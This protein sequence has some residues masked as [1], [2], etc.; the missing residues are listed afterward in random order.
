MNTDGITAPKE[1]VSVP[2]NETRVHFWLI[3]VVQ[4]AFGG[5]LSTYLVFY[6]RSATLS[7]SWPFLLILAAA[8][9]GNEIFKHHY[10][11]LT[12]QISILFLSIY[13]F[14]IF[15]VPVILRKIG[16]QIFILS[17]AISIIILI[18]FLGL[19]YFV[20]KEKF[21]RSRYILIASIVGIIA[22]INILY[23]TNTIPPIPLALK[24]AGVY[25]SI[26]RSPD[27]NYIVTYESGHWY[28]F[29]RGYSDVHEVEGDPI[30]VFSA[31]FSPAMFNTNIVDVWQY[32]DST[33]HKWINSARIPLSTLGGRDDGFRTY[34]EKSNVAAGFWRVSVE[35][36]NG[37]IIGRIKFKVI[38]STTEAPLLA[39]IK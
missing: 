18:V 26:S 14:A 8:F 4:F 25:H 7:V 39:E 23:F 36:A 38:S 21:R 33:S 2:F 6:F 29:W 17:G 34:S 37:E 28:D 35:T 19:F 1:K 27:G 10:T 9:A 30:Y 22:I 31:V 13:S 20:T 12:F 16:P 5:L 24:D 3:I 11:R 15:I 32:Y